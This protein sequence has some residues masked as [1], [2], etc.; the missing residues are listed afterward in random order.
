MERIAQVNYYSRF[1]GESHEHFIERVNLLIRD[2]IVTFIQWIPETE[3]NVLSCY[4]TVNVR[5]REY[6]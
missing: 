3:D 2:S 5:K 4:V 1:N 6:I